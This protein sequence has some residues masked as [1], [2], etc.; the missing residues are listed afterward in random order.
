MAL[1]FPPRI[2]VAGRG[3]S[4]ARH[5]RRILMFAPRMAS[6]VCACAEKSRILAGNRNSYPAIGTLECITVSM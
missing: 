6:R 2:P 1:P 3:F 5:G 4:E